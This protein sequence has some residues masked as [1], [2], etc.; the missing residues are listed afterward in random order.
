MYSRKCIKL[1]EA[2]VQETDNIVAK[3]ALMC[4]Y[5]NMALIAIFN[6]K[7]YLIKAMSLGETFHDPGNAIQKQLLEEMGSFFKNC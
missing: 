4:S 2:L 7:K 5:T 6:K 3:V 1:A